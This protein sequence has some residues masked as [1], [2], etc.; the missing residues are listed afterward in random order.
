[1]NEGMRETTSKEFKEFVKYCKL[2]Q[3]FFG[4][5]DW[6]II[7]NHQTAKEGIGAFTIFDWIKRKVTIYFSTEVPVAD[8]S[9]EDIPLVAFHEMFH[10]VSGNV[11]GFATERFITEEQLQMA[12][13]QLVYLMENR[14]YPLVKREVDKCQKKN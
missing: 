8:P 4:L 13:E 11:Y 1:M 3:K 10:L 12:I 14:V 6:D 7:Y 5:Y 2:Y 9:S